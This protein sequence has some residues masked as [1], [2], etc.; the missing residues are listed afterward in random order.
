LFELLE[1]YPTPLARQL[2]G[3]RILQQHWRQVI[4]RFMATN[5]GRID[6][7]KEYLRSTKGHAGFPEH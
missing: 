7:L 6:Q 3:D 5:P 4:I 2:L 1:F